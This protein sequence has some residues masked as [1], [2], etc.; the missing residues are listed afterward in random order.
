MRTTSGLNPA[1]WQHAPH[2][3]FALSGKHS[4]V[5]MILYLVRV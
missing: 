4:S 3:R 2:V 1:S 5:R